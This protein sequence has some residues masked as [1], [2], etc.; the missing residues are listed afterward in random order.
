MYKP[1]AKEESFYLV[2]CLYR[3]SQEASRRIV[4]LNEVINSLSVLVK[5]KEEQLSRL[6][7]A[8]SQ[9]EKVILHAW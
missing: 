3:L 8:F 7:N 1:Y 2:C 6:K 9:K 4:E 5:E